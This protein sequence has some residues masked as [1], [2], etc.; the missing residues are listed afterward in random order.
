M[1][2]T[3]VYLNKERTA[4]VA[5]SGKSLLELIDAGLDAVAS[6][7]SEFTPS[8]KFTEPVPLDEIPIAGTAYGAGGGGTSTPGATGGPGVKRPPC[9]HSYPD[10]RYVAGTR[11]CRK[12]G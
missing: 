11:V 5:A 3:S 2:R 12:C 6:P 7:P 9:P 10:V 1:A 8:G 4:A